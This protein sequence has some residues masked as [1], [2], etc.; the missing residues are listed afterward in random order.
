MCE[1][2]SI[3]GGASLA[4][5]VASTAM[6]VASVSQ[7]RAVQAEQVEENT[8]AANEAYILETIQLNTR[9]RQEQEAAVQRKNDAQIKTAKAVGSAKVSA[10]AGNVEGGSLNLLLG[11][12]YRSLGSFNDRT[13]QQ[14]ED[15]EEQIGAQ[16]IAAEARRDARIASVPLPGGDGA[17]AGAAI[18]GAG[19]IGTAGYN[20]GFFAPEGPLFGQQTLAGK[21][22][23]AARK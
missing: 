17:F 22:T 15:V 10:A 14:A 18:R 8:R 16:S 21:A 6:E 23:S 7:S 5:A 12:F 2:T 20:S 9:R 3:L 19:R 13:D 1:P 4:L 11:D